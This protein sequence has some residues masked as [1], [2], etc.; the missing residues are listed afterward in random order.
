[1]TPASSNAEVT[2][3]DTQ[4]RWPLLLLLG[5]AIKWLVIAG[6]LSLIASIQLHSPAF[7]SHWPAFTPG[8]TAAM[9]ETAFVYGW[10]FNA[11]LGLALW[12][13]GRLGGEPLRALNWVVVGTFA[14]NIGLT[15]GLVGIALGDATSFS[16]L[17]LPGYVQ[18]AM[19]VAYGAIAVAGI[20]AWSGRRTDSTFASHWY[21]VAAL[22]LFPWLLSAAQATLIWTPVRGVLQAVVAGWYAQGV[23]SLCLAPL[24]LA[25]AYYVVPK[26]TGRALPAYEF[27]P[28]GFWSLIVIGAWTGARHL[29]GGPVPAWLPTLAIAACSLLLFHTSIVL[30]NLRGAIGGAGNSVAFIAWGLL[31]YTAGGLLDAITS[32]RSIA[33]FTQFTHL[34]T[35]QQQLAIY[36][37][38][39]MILFGGIY[40]ALPR[41]TGRPW[42]SAGF[43]SAHRVTLLIGL[44]LLLVSLAAAGWVQANDL[45]HK[46]VTF[47]AMAADTRPWLLGASGAQL[48]LLTANLLLAVNFCRSVCACCCC[49]AESAPVGSPFR[50]AATMEAHAS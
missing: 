12:I 38:V 42:A 1:M 50:P 11:G 40:F 24:A 29:T 6:V 21:A 18:P 2:A 39:S 14:W 23:W 25:V 34:V 46:D 19:L 36:G 31:A 10:A 44:A 41:L 9:A 35:A 13:L 3:V 33:S 5:G 16:L 30:L 22:F 28:L 48:I 49:C 47:A 32:F 15:L 37:G 4:A 7:M 20:L 26:V 43:V 17:Q 45:N 27:A 8:R